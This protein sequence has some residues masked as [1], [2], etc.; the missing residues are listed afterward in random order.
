MQLELK[1]IQREVGI[2]FI[3]VTHDQGEALTMSDRIAVM[4][5]GQVEQI[6]TP[7][8]IYGAPASVFV[9]GFIGS[10]NLLPG[11]LD[12]VGTGGSPGRARQRRARRRSPAPT[13]ARRRRSGDGDAAP[14][15]PAASSPNRRRRAQRRRAPSSDVIYQGS[16]L[17]LIVDLTDGTEVVANVDAD[18]EVPVPRPGD[19][20]VLH[21]AADAP[22]LLRG[23]SAVIGATTTDVDEVQ[24]SLDGTEVTTVGPGTAPAAAARAPLRPPGR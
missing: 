18:D 23:R 13:E 11:T 3:F 5:R 20:V 19:E 15:A 22:Y 21:W 12:A 1:R 10:A 24:A 9:A 8:E 7:E 16:E 6:G 4:S 2:T 17:R 14:G